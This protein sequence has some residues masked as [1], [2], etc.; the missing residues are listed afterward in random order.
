VLLYRVL[1]YIPP[2][3]FGGVCLLFWR[4]VG[5]RPSQ[6]PAAESPG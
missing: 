6:P 3:G 4:R 5:S 2:I 1:T